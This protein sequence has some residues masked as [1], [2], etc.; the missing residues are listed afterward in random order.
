[1]M[2]NLRGYMRSSGVNEPIYTVNNMY[3]D[4]I[5]LQDVFLREK[6]S[7]YMCFFKWSLVSFKR[8]S[9]APP[10]EPCYQPERQKRYL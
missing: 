2:R 5:I 4:F 7:I 9:K 6:I 1:M 3:N 10:A 8:F